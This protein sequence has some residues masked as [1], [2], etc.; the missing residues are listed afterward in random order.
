MNLI[1]LKELEESPDHGFVNRL[2]QEE[3]D[4]C[5]KYAGG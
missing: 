5:R 1:V 3:Y 4:G 2:T